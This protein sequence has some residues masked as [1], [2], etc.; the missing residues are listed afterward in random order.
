MHT[1]SHRLKRRKWCILM[2]CW[3][4]T[5]VFIS[6]WDEA[7]PSL[8]V[9]FQ[10]LRGCCQLWMDAACGAINNSNNK[11]EDN[12]NNSNN[13]NSNNDNDSN[14]EQISD[15]KLQRNYRTNKL[16]LIC[17][18]DIWL[19]FGRPPAQKDP[20]FACPCSLFS[21]LLLLSIIAALL[22]S[23]L[24]S[25]FLF[26]FMRTTIKWSF[27]QRNKIECVDVIRV[28]LN[29]SRRQKKR[30]AKLGLHLRSGGVFCKWKKLLLRD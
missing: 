16:K 15:T 14:N 20:S 2:R 6:R 8:V 28:N 5:R 13:S 23:W 25:F 24:I 17:P 12:K 26:E 22:Q 1:H 3:E 30:L 10:N 9:K 7:T 4:K 29:I 19:N 18:K 21:H 27:F 11:N